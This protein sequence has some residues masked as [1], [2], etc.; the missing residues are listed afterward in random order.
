MFCP[1]FLAFE[2]VDMWV[3]ENV[4]QMTGST[5]FAFEVVRNKRS[6]DVR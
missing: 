4:R 6:I 5:R 3:R 1:L 2:E